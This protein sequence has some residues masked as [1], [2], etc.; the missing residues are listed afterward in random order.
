MVR[1]PRL[2]G[3]L[4]L[5]LMLSGT[6]WS[7]LC[8]VEG[9]VTGEDGSP[10]KGALIKFTRTDGDGKYQVKTDKKGHFYHGGL[11]HGVFK[12]AVEVDGKEV[13]T[14]TNIRTEFPPKVTGIDFDLRAVAAR[15]EQLEKASEGKLTAKEARK[16]SSEDKAAIEA[17]SKEREKLASKNKDLNDAFNA[18][19][20]AFEAKQYDEAVARF[21]R[22]AELD[23]GQNAVW[24]YL[25]QSYVQLG[26]T[27]SGADRQA[28]LEKGCEAYQ[29]ALALKDDAALHGKFALA[30]FKLN[31][32]P[33]AEAEFEKAAVLDRPN[34]ARYYFN[35]GTMFLNAG[36]NDA[37]GN[38]FKKALEANP[39]FAEAQFQYA[40]FLSAK[41]PPPGPDGKVSAPPG[42][43]EALDKYL[44]L[45][46]N[47][48]NAEAARSLIALI[49]SSITTTYQSPKDKSKK[50]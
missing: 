49:G 17:Q 1:M 50:R 40:V 12:V 48:P 47:G 42:M 31:N 25:A 8:A 7:Q 28:A 22:A 37:A 45:E 46:P 27:K 34:A 44:A 24:S 43:K 16:L 3:L 14:V 29:K 13:D 35:M 11:A 33:G 38:A 6:A 39:D 41:M 19:H 21:T 18:G 2:Y 5:S 26:D 10:L 9:N 4:A 32:V 23:S 36:Q 20:A 30:L 15:R